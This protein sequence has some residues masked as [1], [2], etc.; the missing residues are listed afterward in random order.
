MDHFL[1]IKQIIK[2]IR[3]GRLDLRRKLSSYFND[4]IISFHKQNNAYKTSNKTEGEQKIMLT[5]LKISLRNI[6]MSSTDH[7]VAKR[8]L[9]LHYKQMP[10]S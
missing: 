6:K 8:D 7:Y 2:V 10:L 4:H 9:T 1:K 5:I 3:E